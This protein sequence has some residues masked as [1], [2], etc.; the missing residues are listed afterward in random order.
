MFSGLSSRQL[1]LD[2]LSISLLALSLLT[3]CGL[4]TQITPQ[5]GSA[6]TISYPV[7]AISVA[8]NTAM[9]TDTPT[10]TGS[11]TSLTLSPSLPAGLSFNSTTGAISGTPTAT[12]SQTTYTITATN[13]WGS[14][15]ATVAITVTGVAPSNLVYPQTSLST[16]VNIAITTDTPTITGSVTGYSIS[17]S[18][19]AGLSINSTTGAISGTPTTTS[20]QTTYTV[21]ASNSYGS[22]T[23]TVVISVAAAATAPSNLSYPQTY[24]TVPVGTAITT[25]I[26]TVTGNVTSYSISP[27]PPPAGLNFN[28]ALGIISGTP[29][30]PLVQTAYTITASNS[31]GS[32]SAVVTITVTPSSTSITY[33]QTTLIAYVN[34]PIV[35]DVPTAPASITSFSASPALPAGLSINTATG[36]I[37]GTPTTTA[38]QTTYTITGT[39]SSGSL[40]ATVVLTV[41]SAVNVLLDTNHGSSISAVHAISGRLL[42]QDT[43]GH[44]NLWNTSTQALLASGDTTFTADMEG[45]VL[46]SG[47]QNGIEVRS[48]VDGHI[49]RFISSLLLNPSPN[50]Y[51]AWWQLATD[52][53]YIV[54][55]SQFGLDIWSTSTGA[56]VA[57]RTGNY[58]S[59]SIY[60]APTQLQIA[61]S[62]NASGAIETIAIA[63]GVST[64]SPAY[65]GTFSFW[66]LDGSQF[67]TTSAT[68]TDIY[69]NASVLEHVLTLSFT[70]NG[71]YGNYLYYLTN[72]N[73]NCSVQITSI[74][75]SL[76]SYPACNNA[77]GSRN[78]STIL[79]QSG[80]NFT[81]TDLTSSTLATTQYSAGNLSNVPFTFTA[82]D[83]TST[84]HIFIGDSHGLVL[85]PS[86]S[87]N[88]SLGAVAAVAGSNTQTV[89]TTANGTLYD[90]ATS[91]GTVSK[92]ASIYSS[93]LSITADGTLL[94]A[95]PS[96]NWNQQTLYV[97]NFPAMS[98]AWTQSV[99]GAT[100]LDSFSLSP[101]GGVLLWSDDYYGSSPDPYYAYIV[102]LSTNT[103]LFGANVMWSGTRV[104]NPVLLATDGSKY[105]L[106]TYNLYTDCSVNIYVNNLIT[107]AAP[108]NGCAVGWVDTSHVLVDNYV[109]TL[110]SG[111]SYSNA[112]LYDSSGN[113]VATLPVPA[114]TILP[115]N[116][117]SF[118][119]PSTNSVYSASTGAVVWTCTLT[120]NGLGAVSGSDIVYVSGHRVIAEPYQ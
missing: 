57:T 36:A 24:I 85:S 21:T 110:G 92:T 119:M 2:W 62:P 73:F 14:A 15:T 40:T 51:K 79:T 80:T 54:A 59:T 35:S 12:S 42:S 117:S 25:D 23:A 68:N 112:L 33:P 49:V 105:T 113:L 38:A 43:S 93:S 66:F 100:N 88:F 46:A 20:S 74:T 34:F 82:Y 120:S 69:T 76:S 31:Y 41:K 48:T 109:F 102:N 108:L 52:G 27:S 81:V 9:S 10:I 83:A 103:T 98:I 55:G 94:A 84:A 95:Y 63:T 30:A 60:P 56:V 77:Y 11:P 65:A 4:G 104:S 19:P 78:T 107:T 44:W 26:P 116:S 61:L 101:T 32:T 6:P 45:T 91:S 75:S 114:G 64:I 47:V 115:I 50:T 96:Y 58:S 97:Y 22:T 18:L 16:N 89:L 39:G 72:A 118:Y 37:S 17:P 53:S 5:G 99:T 8:V 1:S 86:D 7:T 87:T 90:I 71:G 70:P 106:N 13:S 111:V 29:T 67:V 3:G 28:T